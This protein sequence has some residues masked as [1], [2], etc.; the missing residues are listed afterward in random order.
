MVEGS[1]ETGM[2]TLIRSIPSQDANKRGTDP[3]FVAVVVLL[4]RTYPLQSSSLS[5]QAV[6]TGLATE[7]LLGP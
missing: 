7:T 6:S 3:V 5:T 4:D 2:P 1:H